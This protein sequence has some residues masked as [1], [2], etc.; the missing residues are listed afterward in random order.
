MK[1]TGYDRHYKDTLPP[2]DGMQYQRGQLTSIQRNKAKLGFNC[3]HCGVAF[4]TY[5]CWAKRYKYHYCGRACASAAKVIRIPKPCVVCGTEMLLPPGNYK[6]VS[7]CSTECMRKR[8]VVNYTNLRAS[9]DYSAITRRL[10]HAAVCTTCKTTQGPWV[11]QGIKTWVE[12]GLARAN[13]DDAYLLCQSC[14]LKSVAPLS[15]QSTYMS[16]RFKYY[17][18]KNLE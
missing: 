2:K 11:V 17:K 13:G 18:E 12:D 10:K 16:D 5:A 4:E 6:R 7:A 9:P 8:R 15:R 1:S 14:H 3:D